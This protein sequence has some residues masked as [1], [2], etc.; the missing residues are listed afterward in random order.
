[1]ELKLDDDRED[2]DADED[3]A[4]QGGETKK[5]LPQIIEQLGN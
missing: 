3:E 1:M 4:P 2:G 5:S